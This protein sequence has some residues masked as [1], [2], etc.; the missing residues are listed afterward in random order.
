[1]TDRRNVKSDTKALAVLNS[2]VSSFESIIAS[3]ISLAIASSPFLKGAFEK[4]ATNLLYSL[5]PFL[6]TAPPA[7][8]TKPLGSL[9]FV[10]SLLTYR[11]RLESSA[12]NPSGSSL[13]HRPNRGLY[14][15]AR[16]YCNPVSTCHSRA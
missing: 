13:D 1:M 4:S 6:R 11:W 9:A 15:L 5:V 3:K 14:H 10:G 16:L 8:N 7:F 12:R 2:K